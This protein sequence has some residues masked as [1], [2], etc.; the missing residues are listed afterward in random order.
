MEDVLG[1]APPRHILSDL[2][3]VR[4]ARDQARLDFI[5]ATLKIRE[6]GLRTV[7][8]AHAGLLACA[9][10]WKGRSGLERHSG[11]EEH[12]GLERHGASSRYLMWPRVKARVGTGFKSQT[13]P[14]FD[15]IQIR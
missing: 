11:L 13:K 15:I 9:D 10:E 1:R 12:R 3:Q 14:T 4:V 8:L 6:I 2:A 7:R 5:E